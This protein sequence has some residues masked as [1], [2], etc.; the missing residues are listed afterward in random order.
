VA[1]E[2]A[3]RR[4]EAE[5]KKLNVG[6]TTDYFVLEFQEASSDAMSM[7]LKALVD[8]NLALARLEKVLGRSLEQRNMKIS[9]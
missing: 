7:E 3:E 6:L 8:Y 4:L 9:H 1:R 2:L 5:V